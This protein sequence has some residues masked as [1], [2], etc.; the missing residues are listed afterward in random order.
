MARQDPEHWQLLS[1]EL[2]RVLDIQGQARASYLAALRERNPSLADE[3]DGLLAADEAAQRAGFLEQGAAALLPTAATRTGDPAPPFAVDTPPLREGSVFGPYRIAGVIG[4]G[5]MGIV[6]DAD[7]IESGRRVALKVLQGRL[8][9]VRERE[10]FERE[11]RLAASITHEHCVFVFGASEIAGLPAI[12]MERMA[13]TLGDRLAA[14]GGPLAPGEA[15]DAALQLVSGLRA[16]AAAGVLHRDVKPSNCFVDAD[17]VVKIG[18]FGISRSLRPTEETALTARGHV[19]ATPAYASPEQLRGATVDVRSDIYSLGATLYELLTGRRPFERSDLMA[20]LMAVANDRPAAPH[21]VNRAVPKGLGDVVLRCLAKDPARRYADYDALERALEPYASAAPTPATVG[22]RFLAGLVDHLLLAALTLPMVVLW[23][24]TG[25]LRM[26]VR[27]LS[28]Q[29]VAGLVL[30]A[31]YYGI[32]AAWSA[33]PGKMLLGLRLV[34]RGGRPATGVRVLGRAALFALGPWLTGALWV[35]LSPTVK[36]GIAYD[37]QWWHGPALSGLQYAWLALLFSTV[38]RRNGYAGLHDLATGLRVVARRAAEAIHGSPAAIVNAAATPVETRVGSFDVSAR[39]IDGMPEAWRWGDDPR[40]RRPVWVR[41]LPPGS[42]PVSQAR[43]NVTRQT[44]LRWLA[45]R[46][47]AAEAWDVFEPV[48]GR[49]FVSL[50]GERGRWSDVRRWLLDLARELARAVPDEAAPPRL[51]RVWITTNG[52]AKLVDDPVLDAALPQAGSSSALLGELARAA[53]ARAGGPWPVAAEAFLARLDGQPDAD[54]ST[55]VG[56]L[57]R[58]ADSRASVTRAWRAA[59]LLVPILFPLFT[60]ALMVGGVLMF[61]SRSAKLTADERAVIV[62]LQTLWS[63]A[64]G[65]ATL[66]ADDRDGLETVLATR[67]RPILTGGQLFT[68]ENVF[69]GLSPQHQD[70]AAQILA[71]HPAGAASPAVMERPAVRRVQ[72]RAAAMNAPP[73]MA[74]FAAMALSISLLFVAVP[75]LVIAIACRGGILRVLGFEY[76]TDDGR[77]AS[78][79]RVFARTLVAWSPLLAVPAAL[80]AA[81]VLGTEPGRSTFALLLGTGTAVLAAGAVWAIVTPS[82]GPADRLAGTWIVPR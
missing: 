42:P 62:A 78:R 9:D 37:I 27:Q 31:A 48:Q 28:L 33:S 75:A 71:R 64:R 20:L 43:A 17:G 53:K 65:P 44:R 81:A 61:S 57:E 74:E 80:G 2:D 30:F 29:H 12:A 46:R 34:D 47:T 14:R 58:L 63:D 79:L 24:S 25:G 19:A 5:G 77:R 39:A 3:L 72:S 70:L 68:P 67:Y 22:R 6:Y 38:R 55:A 32:E 26:E 50:A 21:V 40:L 13:G 18:D 54:P 60:A 52:H 51:D 23:Y 49:P 66:S 8:D 76:V 56:D 4:R 36:G 82:R 7:E 73:P 45:G 41:L 35:A 1:A 10:M 59:A 11:G 69:L 16:A 15:V